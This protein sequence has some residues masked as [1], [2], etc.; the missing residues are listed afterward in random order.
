MTLSAAALGIVELPSRLV[1]SVIA[2]SVAIAAINN[3]LPIVSRRLWIAAF[4][5]GLMHGFGFA[6]VL[7]DLGLPPARKLVAL[8][9]FN[10]GVEL[11]TVVAC[12]LPVLFWIRGTAAYTRVALPAGSMVI[13]VIGL[14]WFVQRAI[15]TSTIF[16]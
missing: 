4:V 11:L 10:V 12:L 9:S 16:G 5:F 6:G 2:V 8:L 14:L 7:T 15:G 3:L 13:A 1:E